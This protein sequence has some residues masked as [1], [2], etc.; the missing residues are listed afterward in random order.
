MGRVIPIGEF[1]QMTRLS[2]KALRLYD[3][4]GLLPAARVDPS[5]G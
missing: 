2:L 1:S 5:T 3:S 4:N